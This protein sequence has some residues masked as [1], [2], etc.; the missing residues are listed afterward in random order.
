MNAVALPHR[1]FAALGV[2]AV[3]ATGVGCS[4]SVAEK[5]RAIK[6][7]TTTSTTTSTST[8]TTTAAPIVAPAGL[9]IGARSA[10]VQEL[11]TRLNAQKY[12]TGKVDGYFDSATFH[13]VMTFQKAHGLTR[14]GRATDNVLNLIGTVGAPGPMLASGGATR[15]E[16]DL[17]RQ[18]LQLYKGGSLFKV[19][20]VSTG[21]GKRYCVDGDCATAVTPGGS[22]K[23]FFRRNG[24]R[25]S[26]LGKL[27]NP[28]YFNGGIAIHGAP[29]VP[30]YPASHG[31]VRIPMYVAE[32]F[33]SQVPNG[34]PVYVIGG[35]RAAV[36]FNEPAP[37]GTTGT[38]GPSTS[39]AT[40]T[41]APAATTTSSPP[42]PPPTSQ[43]PTTTTTTTT[44]TTP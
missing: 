33:H 41:T 3:A 6:R 35:S 23:V 25:V 20:D 2:L 26:R 43:P 31:C 14:T 22:Y 34:T 10:E 30:A 19:L 27:Y 13:A 36:P 17:K 28:L 18:I 37:D 42:F 1:F 16:V 44:S 5:P 39:A 4:Q 7:A 32:W 15:V 29:S 24:W 21:S 8:T 38:G 9:G 11:E 40:T 12:D